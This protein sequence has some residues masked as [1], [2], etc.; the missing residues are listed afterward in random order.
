MSSAVVSTAAAVVGIGNTLFGGSS[1]SGNVAGGS[2]YDPYASE[3]P[4]FFSGLKTLMGQSPGE[5]T[6]SSALAFKDWQA[7]NPKGT[8]AQY[9]VYSKNFKPVTTTSVG[10]PQAALDMVYNSPGY[11]GGLQQ[12][13]RVLGANLAKTGQV[14]SGAEKIAL[15]N[16]GQDYFTQQY[17]NLYNQYTGLSQ[18]TAQP[19][20]MANQNDLNFRQNQA[21]QTNL[22]ASLGSLTSNFQNI[23]SNA[24]WLPTSMQNTGTPWTANWGNLDSGQT[25][26]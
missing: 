15:N 6:T 17:Q 3:R 20:S 2:Y 9:N 21:N 18:A 4:Q 5:T 8:A 14:E 22:G 10:G 11:M 26:F 13:Q 19:L 23:A 24:T 7:Q 12:G 16:L 1:S 25:P